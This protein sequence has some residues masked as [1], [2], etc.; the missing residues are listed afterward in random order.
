VVQQKGTASN[1]AGLGL[2]QGQHHLHGNGGI[3]GATASAQYLVTRVS[4]QGVGGG[5]SKFLVRPA[6]F[7]FVP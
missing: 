3:N 2:N 6:F 7:L 1:A 5:N 4:R